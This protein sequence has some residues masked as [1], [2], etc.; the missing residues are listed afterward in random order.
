MNLLNIPTTASYFR[1]NLV[2]FLILCAFSLGAF[3]V[4]YLTSYTVVSSFSDFFGGSAAAVFALAAVWEV[5]KAYTAH[6]FFSDFYTKELDIVVLFFFTA[7]WLSAFILGWSG[8][9]T[10]HQQKQIELITA[11]STAAG[12]PTIA[13]PAD[14]AT[15]KT[16]QKKYLDALK[17]Q[18]ET[19]A[20]AA[21]AEEKKREELK[22]LS[23][24]GSERAPYI[25]L[26]ADLIG[27][28]SIAGATHIAKHKAKATE[29]D[30]DQDDEA[31]D[32]SS[33][34]EINARR[35]L[36]IKKYQK[37]Y[38]AAAVAGNFELAKDHADRIQKLGGEIPKT[39]EGGS[40]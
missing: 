34:E 31:D 27:L 35:Q 2:F 37:R 23:K 3:Y 36:E 10:R 15:S 38:T 30:D 12:V 18:A 19:A 21:E 8:S 11:D 7:L 6:R 1:K 28:L 17:A 29:A 33:E 22:Q 40:R 20:K 25:F 24:E 4:S 16:L 9:H 26:I 13:P 5:S 39:R 14:L 32:E